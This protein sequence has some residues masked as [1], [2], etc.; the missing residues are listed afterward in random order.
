[1]F[2]KQQNIFMK[3]VCQFVTEITFQWKIFWLSVNVMDGIKVECMF[4]NQFQGGRKEL[5]TK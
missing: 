5:N 4:H 3:K 1:M 2:P